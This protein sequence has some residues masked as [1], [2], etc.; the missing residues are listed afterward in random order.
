MRLALAVPILSGAMLSTATASA[1]TYDVWSCRAPDGSPAI[2]RDDEGGWRSRSVAI[3]AG[4][5]S[6]IED[7]C[8]SGELVIAHVI[9]GS[10]PRSSSSGWVFTPP[11]KTDIVSYDL[12]LFGRLRGTRPGQGT[13]R[14]SLSVGHVRR[15]DGYRESFL[16]EGEAHSPSSTGDTSV[17]PTVV[18]RAE[19]TGAAE[20][21]VA[22]ECVGSEGDRCFA[23]PDGSIGDLN[24]VRSTIT[25]RDVE[26]PVVTSAQGDA[27][28]AGVWPPSG[29]AMTV[30]ATDRGGGILRIGVEIDG[31]E[32]QW[33]PVAAAP[34]RI[35]PGTARAFVA[36]KPCPSASSTTVT[37]PTASLAAG[38][39]SVRVLVEDAAGNQTT[40]Y[41]PVS[42]RISAAVGP[43]GDGV[44]PD[45]EPPADAGDGTA[46][47][48]P[49]VLPPS[50]PIPPSVFPPVPSVATPISGG[51]TPAADPGPPNGTPA[52]SRVR[53][54]A[55]WD[56]T[57]SALRKARFGQRPVLRGQLTTTDGRPVRDAAIRVGVTQ[58]HRSASRVEHQALR[59]DAAGSFRWRLPKGVGSRRIVLAYYERVG[60]TA[61]AASRTLRLQVAAAVQMTLDRRT[62]RQG[63][64]VRLRGRLVGRPLPKVGSVIELQ[65]RNPGRK[66]I[67]FRTIRANRAGR[68]RASYRFRMPGP[69]V[70]QMRARVRKSGDYPYTTGVSPHRRIVVR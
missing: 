40:A 9:S 47:I 27:V 18:V 46:P 13:A 4:G 19:E 8:S 54:S 24:L 36:P 43:G 65:A 58:D 38:V 34:C 51:G 23:G 45:P 10:Q 37:I 70:F 60:G 16:R 25:L 41:G 28:N 29:V 6:R 49:S 57:T 66:W 39:H 14:G 17:P 50:V 56:G 21:S 68:F 63:Q 7:Q 20:V 52:T 15:S 2:V 35:W 31:G 30:D 1:G 26:A 48:P 59:T 11:E 5:T 67:T 42:K 62:A 3:D 69:A 32:P 22:V 12:S 61:P 64:T 53:L 55:R 44:A 33:H